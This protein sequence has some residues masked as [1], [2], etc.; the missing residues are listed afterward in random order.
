M[1]FLRYIFSVK[2]RGPLHRDVRILGFRFTVRR[3]LSKTGKYHKLPIKD[4][5]IVFCTQA[6]AYHCSAK[7]IAEEIRRRNLPY[8]QVWIVNR[9]ILRHYD[10][11]PKDVKLVMRGTP[12]ALQELASAKI[13]IENE[14]KQEELKKGLR[15]KKG[16][17]YINT[18]HGSLGIK[19]TGNQRSDLTADKLAY[20]H[21]DSSLLNYAI[22]NST[23]TTN[24]YKEIFWG[25]GKSLEM[26][27][28]RNDIFFSDRRDAI[29]SAICKK[30]G[31]SASCKILLYAP[32]WRNSG[33][34]ACFT[35][36]YARAL[37]AMTARFGG[38]WVLAVRLH[39]FMA[40]LEDIFFPPN[41][42]VVN[43]TDHADM[44]EILVSAD[45]VITDYSSCIYDYI[46]LRRPGF[47]YAPDMHA[48][49]TGR[50]LCYPLE[51][52]PFSLA[53]NNDEMENNIRQFD[54]SAYIARV[55]SFLQ[56]KGSI[57]DGH[58]CERVVDFIRTIV[59]GKYADLP[60]QAN[61]IVL[62]SESGAYQCNLKYIAEE[63]RNQGLSYDLVWVV[64]ANI[65][66]YY[67]A[68]PKDIRLVMQGTPDALQELAT[69]KI[70]IDN[71]LKLRKQ[72]KGQ[73]KRPGQ[74]YIRTLKTS[75]LEMPPKAQ[76][77]KKSAE[78]K[79]LIEKDY[80]LIDYLILN[81]DESK[82]A[83]EDI[84]KYEGK[85]LT[86]GSPKNDIFFPS[87]Q[88]E[89]RRK[90][91]ENLGI[92]A[93]KKI[94]LYAPTN[95]ADSPSL[96]VARVLSAATL[97]YGGEWI[98]LA[99]SPRRAAEQNAPSFLPNPAVLDVS[100]YT[101][102]RELLAS[103]D[104]L[105]T[106]HSSFAR[107]FLYTRKPEFIYAPAADHSD[108]DQKQQ[109]LQMGE[110]FSTAANNDELE[111]LITQFDDSAYNKRVDSFLQEKG[112]IDDGH[113]TERVVD[114]IKNI[115]EKPL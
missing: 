83:G 34:T 31:I 54:E 58:A 36:D 25:F 2:N 62:H 85:I 39:P 106:D 73:P 24:F 35:L 84:C 90:V 29:R 60:I 97:R 46:L 28:P 33:D 101:D 50:G 48:Y 59:E 107:D 13:W 102:I 6:G 81:S 55:E 57:D 64:D 87:H 113:A 92:A 12:E 51:E 115:I 68:Y 53:A 71:S 10:S 30:L 1:S 44:Q 89:T 111:L 21:A 108:N 104:A 41:A 3:K 69:A 20:G 70:I 47:I 78:E 67:D 26:G 22:S 103:A 27:C 82:Y 43:A 19:K 52:T 72:M 56:G 93:G 86:Y 23:Y 75:P 105:I 42:P 110:P 5:K 32:T 18:W 7:Y 80:T 74:V 45:A 99:Y 114:L 61:K 100:H 16:Q 11:Y 88:D 9:N 94:L 76:L 65:L 49:S 95:A 14:R 79:A 66:K 8:E 4:T 15:K 63:I 37:Q 40:G 77:K 96:D 38:E 98:L 112:C 17:V 91:C 109:L